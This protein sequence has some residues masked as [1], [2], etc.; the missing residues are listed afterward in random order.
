MLQFSNN[1]NWFKN[2]TFP[3][4]NMQLINLPPERLLATMAMTIYWY[5]RGIFSQS[6]VIPSGIFDGILKRLISGSSLLD[7]PNLFYRA[8][9][10]SGLVREFI[11]CH[12]YHLIFFKWVILNIMGDWSECGCAG[13]AWHW[14][15]RGCSLQHCWLQQSGS[16]EAKKV[17]DCLTSL[18]AGLHDSWAK[19]VH[20]KAK[21]Q[22]SSQYP[23]FGTTTIMARLCW[24]GGTLKNLFSWCPTHIHP[25]FV[26][27]VIPYQVNPWP[28]E[29]CLNTSLRFRITKS[30]VWWH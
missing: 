4:N 19:M 22:P 8:P 30:K 3:W 28:V 5:L 26:C 11:G 18:L 1:Y 17:L 29:M 10:T 25:T 20:S 23:I 13:R 24:A 21:F 12:C 6:F 14:D 16:Q 2:H 9:C 7:C 15:R 27:T